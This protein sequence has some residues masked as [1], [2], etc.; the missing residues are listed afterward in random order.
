[1]RTRN[2]SPDELNTINRLAFDAADRLLRTLT[3]QPFNEPLTVYGIAVGMMLW[4]I[5]D[6]VGP[7]G[8]EVYAETIN[9]L[10]DHY[11]HP[12]RLVITS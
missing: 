3:D 6:D 7:Q 5:F 1:M 4:G 2:Y 9:L 12:W 11:D 8:R 10:A